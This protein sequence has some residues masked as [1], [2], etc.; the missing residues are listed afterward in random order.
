MDSLRGGSGGQGV[1]IGHQPSLAV[2]AHAAYASVHRLGGHMH[3]LSMEQALRGLQEVG[4]PAARQL[5]GLRRGQFG[6]ALR[7]SAQHPAGPAMDPRPV[8]LQDMQL[9]ARRQ[10]FAMA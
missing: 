7:D 6:Q 4:C 2:Q 3:R 9:S 10:G 5:H 1:Q 8:K